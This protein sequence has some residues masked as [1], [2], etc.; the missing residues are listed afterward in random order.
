MSTLHELQCSSSCYNVFH[1]HIDFLCLPKLPSLNE[2]STVTFHDNPLAH[3]AELQIIRI[4]G[5][6]RKY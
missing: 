3:T 6:N 4:L 1:A 5:L 2:T